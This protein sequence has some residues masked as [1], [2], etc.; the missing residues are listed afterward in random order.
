MIEN[1]YYAFH[2]VKSE[3]EIVWKQAEQT[4]ASQTRHTI[5][6]TMESE[7]LKLRSSN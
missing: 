1:D 4:Q 3:G 6:H 7:E 5:H 2:I